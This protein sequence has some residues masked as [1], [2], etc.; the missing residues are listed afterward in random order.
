MGGQAFAASKPLLLTPRMPLHIYALVLA[1]THAILRKYYSH[2]ETAVEAPGKETYG[3]VDIA[4]Y[5]PLDPTWCDVEKGSAIVAEKLAEA[6]GAKKFL[7]Q[8]G[9]PTVNFAIPWP[10]Q[11]S[12]DDANE[13]RYVQLDVQTCP[14]LVSFKWELFHA[15]HGDLWNILGSTIRPFGLTVNNQGMYLRIPEIELNDRKRSMVHLTSDPSQVL[16]F[17]GLAEDTWWTPFRNKEEMFEYAA[18]CR[19]FWIKKADDSIEPGEDKADE[20]AAKATQDIEGQEGGE[21]G[22][23]KLKHNDRL[24]MTKRPIFREWMDEF[25]PRCREQGKFEEAKTSREQ[26]QEEAIAEFGVREEYDTRLKEWKLMKH[27][28]DLWGVVIKGSVPIDGIDPALRAA[29]VRTLKVTIMEGV[30]FEGVTPKAAV[31]DQDGFYDLEEVQRFV[32]EHWEKAGRVG[33]ARQEVKAQETMKAKAEKREREAQDKKR[34][35][36]PT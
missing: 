2:V 28:E 20:I 7:T 29:A 18:G 15:A 25:I 3:D 11:D 23:L 36:V 22:K 26:I 33:L 27:L 6:L 4:V 14:S 31:K 30:E 5:G 13:D 1:Q 35:E 16:R 9:S 12:D 8:K 17:L 24:R 34:K 19:M 32:L 10:E 21:K